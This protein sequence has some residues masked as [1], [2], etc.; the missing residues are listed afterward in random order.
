MPVAAAAACFSNRLPFRPRCIYAPPCCCC[1]LGHQCEIAINISLCVRGAQRG[2]NAIESP[3]IASFVW[4]NSVLIEPKN[5]N[6][7]LSSLLLSL[8]LFLC[9]DVWC[10]ARGVASQ[11]IFRTYLGVCFEARGV[12]KYFLPSLSRSSSTAGVKWLTTGSL[13]GV[14]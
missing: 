6:G 13:G 12:G 7:I 10:I 3:V 9:M 1:C 8:S 4:G 5:L 2:S 14:V 11:H